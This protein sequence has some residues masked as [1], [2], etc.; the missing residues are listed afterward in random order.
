MDHIRVLRRA[1]EIVRGYRVLWIFG[2]IL[3]LT[4]NRGGNPQS[5]YSFDSSDTQD[6]RFPFPRD[7]PNW[8]E[9]FPD[10]NFTPQ[11]GTTIVSIVIAL[12]C[13]AVILAVIFAVLRYVSIAASIRMVDH[14]ET[15]GEKLSFRSGWRLG[16]TRSALRLFLIDLL[17]GTGLFLMFLVL[18]AVAAIPLVLWATRNEVAGI[19]G[20]VSTVGLFTLGI[21]LLIVV[22]TLVSLL[23][24]FFHRA[25]MLENRGVFDAISRGWQVFRRRLGD[26]LIMGLILFGIGLLAAIALIP[27]FFLLA[28]TGAVVGGL[29]GLGVGLLVSQLSQANFTAILTGLLIGLPIFLLVVAVPLL[30]ING[31]FEVFYSSTWTLV[32]RELTAQ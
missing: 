6:G 30:F 12:I 29:P 19:L 20:T 25:V 1:F 4:T 10:W 13:L 14:Y 2:L 5:R 11:M 3:A 24:Q 26:V 32:Y 22:A 15:T 8:P 21:L 31:L 9:N 18:A 28:M 7:M 16:W 23:G 17:F 27:V